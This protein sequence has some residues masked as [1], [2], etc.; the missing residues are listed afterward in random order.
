[1]PRNRTLSNIIDANLRPVAK[2]T[3]RKRAKVPCDCDKCKGKSVDPRTKKRHENKISSQISTMN[4][5]TSQEVFEDIDTDESSNSS[6]SVQ[7]EVSMQDIRRSV[8][9]E[10][11]QNITDDNLYDDI[12]FDFLPRE[13]ISRYTT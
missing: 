12:D 6:L 11:V 2:K 3:K 13:R 7:D 10:E 5:T 8:D 4:N 1:M 9:I